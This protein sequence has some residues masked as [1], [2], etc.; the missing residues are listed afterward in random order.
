MSTTDNSSIIVQI[1]D[2]DELFNHVFFIRTK[3]FVDEEKIDQEDEYDGFDHLSTHYLAWV[4]GK[5][6]GT[7]RWRT[8]PIS[9]QIRLERFAV[10]QEFR[11]YGVASAL[12]ER[13]M[14]D[15]SHE[16]SIFVHAQVLVQRF[17]EKFGFKPIGEPF[18]EAGIM[19]QK[20]VYDSSN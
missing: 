19:H 15:V 2:S 20:L 7:A 17:F 4:N 1:V 6:A 8:L 18:E 10:V 13:M 16:N 9:G 12:L 3:V 14:N 5:P 11:K